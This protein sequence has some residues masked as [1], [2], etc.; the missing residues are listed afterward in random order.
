MSQRCVEFCRERQCKS[1]GSSR[2]LE[3]TRIGKRPEGRKGE[4]KAS[5]LYTVCGGSAASQPDA[6]WCMIQPVRSSPYTLKCTYMIN[7]IKLGLPLMVDF[8]CNV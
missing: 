8:N 7:I 3:A 5:V 1:L 4:S 2:D 6:G